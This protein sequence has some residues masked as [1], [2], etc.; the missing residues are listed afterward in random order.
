MLR[1]GVVGRIWCLCVYSIRF[2][3]IYLLI[4]ILCIWVLFLRTFRPV[5]KPSHSSNYYLLCAECAGIKCL[6]FKVP[7]TRPGSVS[8]NALDSGSRGWRFDPSRGRTH[9]FVVVGSSPGR[10]SPS[11]SSLRGG[12]SG[13][14][15]FLVGKVEPPGVAPWLY[16]SRETEQFDDIVL[17]PKAEV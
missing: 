1:H 10:G 7:I 13:Y 11:L 15:E 3:F 16:R 14:H 2:A 12:Y 9:D 6:Y 4:F 5:A 8:R 17:H